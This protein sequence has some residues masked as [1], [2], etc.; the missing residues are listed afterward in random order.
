MLQIA[1]SPQ[2]LSSPPGCCWRR[3]FGRIARADSAC[4][5]CRANDAF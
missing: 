1:R 4:D 3:R 2:A 5:N